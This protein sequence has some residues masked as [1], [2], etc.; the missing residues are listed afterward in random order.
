MVSLTKG[1][2][3]YIGAAVLIGVGF[4]LIVIGEQIAGMQSIGLGLSLLGIRHK[5]SYKK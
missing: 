3:G 2:K 4:Y 1:W 5:L